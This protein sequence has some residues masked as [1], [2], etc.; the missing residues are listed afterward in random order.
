[1]I[2]RMG[3]VLRRKEL[4]SGARF[5]IIFARDTLEDPMMNEDRDG[6]L[7]EI[8]DISESSRIFREDER[9]LLTDFLDYSGPETVPDPV[10]LGPLRAGD[11]DPDSDP[12]RDPDPD[13]N[14]T[15]GTGPVC[16][17]SD[18]PFPE[19]LPEALLAGDR[20]AWAGLSAEAGREVIDRVAERVGIEALYSHVS[21]LP[22]DRP[23]WLHRWVWDRVGDEPAPDTPGHEAESP[24]LAVDL[25]EL[26]RITKPKPKKHRLSTGQR[27]VQLVNTEAGWVVRC[28]GCGTESAPTEFK[29]QALDRTVHCSCTDWD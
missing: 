1:M 19:G 8:E 20:Q 21:Y 6:F 27:P 26:P 22:W 13:R 7:E 2:Q 29:W 25:T 15:S 9:D 11:P 5:V 18:R 24:Y 28:A 3:R 10:Q 23:T 14:G 4:G 12:D 17:G 16:S